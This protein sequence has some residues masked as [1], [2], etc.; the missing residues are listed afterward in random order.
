MAQKGPLDARRGL[1]GKAVLVRCRSAVSV[2]SGAFSHV[3]ASQF[4]AG[5]RGCLAHL[6]TEDKPGT[7]LAG[8]VFV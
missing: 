6:T 2:D 1:S 7:M 4:L 5:F 3:S 8:V